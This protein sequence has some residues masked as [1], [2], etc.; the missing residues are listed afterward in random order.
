MKGGEMKKLAL[1][2]FS[3]IFIFGLAQISS[4]T[5][6]G[7]KFCGDENTFFDL[8]WEKVF[9]D[10]GNKSH[11]WIFDLDQPLEKGDI[12][13]EDKITSAKLWLGIW[14]DKDDF[15]DQN[16]SEKEYANLYL[17]GKQVWNNH[18]VSWFGNSFDVLSYLDDHIL[19]VKMELV[20]GDFGSYS[21]F[22]K[23][24]YIDKPAPVPEPATFF[25]LG[26]GLVCI[27][28]FGKKRFKK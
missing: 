14:D 2:I 26:S 16:D 19:S 4:A 9:F 10:D 8:Q 11:T 28:R 27:F 5:L 24:C 15:K 18:E 25:L 22:V 1:I 12:G 7:H 6:C 21:A 17:G 13:P 3:F 23:G 20:K